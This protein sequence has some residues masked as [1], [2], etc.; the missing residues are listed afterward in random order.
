MQREEPREKED[1]R[2]SS[3]VQKK[4]VKTFHRVVEKGLGGP[5]RVAC[6][7]RDKDAAEGCIAV[8]NVIYLA[9]HVP[10]CTNS[11]L[12]ARPLKEGHKINI[13][14]VISTSGS[15]QKLDLKMSPS[16]ADTS[17]ICWRDG[18]LNFPTDSRPRPSARPQP[19]LSL[20]VMSVCPGPGLQQSRDLEHK[21]VP[22]KATFA[23]TG[24]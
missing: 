19:F 13:K 2:P 5:S 17:I 8:D 21:S 16:P 7:G 20:S 15:S 22:S 18:K 12:F 10:P 9:D 14:R 3:H 4:E 1:R 6:P 24:D 23:F 11:N